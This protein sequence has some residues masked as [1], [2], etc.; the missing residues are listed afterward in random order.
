MIRKKPKNSHGFTL[1]ELITVIVVLGILSGFTF[2]FVEHA[3]KTYS[4]GKRQRMLYQEAS[5]IM[6]RITREMRDARTVTVVNAG[7][8]SSTLYVTR[9]Y[10]TDMDN[11]LSVQFSRTGNN[12]MRIGTNSRILGSKVTQFKIDPDY[13][14]GFFMIYNCSGTDERGSLNITISVRD[15]DIPINDISARTITLVTKI[16][17]KNYTPTS[18][19]YAGRSFNGDYEDVIQ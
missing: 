3:V 6:E 7:L 8:D 12:L 14:S 11:D 17:P 10:P 4:I 19:Q 9:T 18:N 16:S 15:D 1:I 13:C 2:S 5:Y